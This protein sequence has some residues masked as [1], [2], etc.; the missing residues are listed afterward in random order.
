MSV[1]VEVFGRVVVMTVTIEFEVVVMVLTT[2]PD[3]GAGVE[4]ATTMTVDG[5]VRVEVVEPASIPAQNVCPPLMESATSVPVCNKV[6][7]RIYPTCTS[8]AI[9]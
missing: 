7:I 5:P 4:A 9:G 6:R 3:D 1:L 8:P 2:P